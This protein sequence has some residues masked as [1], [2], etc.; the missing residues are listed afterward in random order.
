[1]KAL[2]WKTVVKRENP[3]QTHLNSPQKIML[4][5]ERDIKGHVFGFYIRRA[6]LTWDVNLSL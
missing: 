5:A 6:L 2:D 1:M 4:N 3:N